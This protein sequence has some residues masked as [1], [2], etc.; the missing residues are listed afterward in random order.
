[1]ERS[2]ANCLAAASTAAAAAAAAAA[3]LESTGD[4][5]DRIRMQCNGKG[6]NA[7]I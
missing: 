1:M 7:K 5:V 6:V 3:S 2:E 4:S